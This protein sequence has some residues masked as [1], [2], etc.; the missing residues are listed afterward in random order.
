MMELIEIQVTATVALLLGHFL[1]V[2]RNRPGRVPARN[3]RVVCYDDPCPTVPAG[4]TDASALSTT[5]EAIRV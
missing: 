4:S 2:V 5:R 1:D 3:G